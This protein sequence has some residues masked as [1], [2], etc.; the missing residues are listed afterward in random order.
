MGQEEV[1]DQPTIPTASAPSTP[2]SAAPSP[3]RGLAAFAAVLGL[4]LQ[5][6]GNLLAPAALKLMVPVLTLAG[7][8]VLAS[9]VVAEPTTHQLGLLGV[10]ALF[11]LALVALTRR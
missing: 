11:A 5:L 7:G 8:F 9:Q 3:Q 2:P 6:L 1:P 10:Y 4:F